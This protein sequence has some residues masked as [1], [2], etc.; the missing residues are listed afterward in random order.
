[1]LVA[2][3]AVALSGCD[4]ARRSLGLGKQPPDEFQ[5]VSRAPLS[6]PP[7]FGLRP[8]QPGAER[9]QET[10]PEEQAKSVLFGEGAGVQA[11]AS[12]GL[13][14]LLS[15][16]AVADADP[17]IRT[18]INEDNAILAGDVS[19][20]DRLIFWREPQDRETVIDPAAEAERLADNAALGQPV[21]AGPTPI[22]ERR[23]K[24]LFEDLF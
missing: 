12:S 3:L 16:A 23:E 19:F 22:I 15:R 21:T 2:V 17:E 1:M 5:V 20:T 7:D 8:P 11:T 6:V 13:A 24:A 9:P 4:S 18:R 10:S 14:V